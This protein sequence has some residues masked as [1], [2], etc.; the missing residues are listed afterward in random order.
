[1]KK[2]HTVNLICS[3]CGKSQHEVKKLIAGPSVYICDECI[4]LCNQIIGE[5]VSPVARAD[6]SPESARSLIGQLI[7]QERRACELLRVCVAHAGSAVPDAVKHAA[8]ELV[9]ASRSFGAAAKGWGSTEE[10]PRPPSS[11]PVW[12][13]PCLARLTGTAEV[14]QALRQA[15][16]GV[17]PGQRLKTIDHALGEI[18]EGQSAPD[19]RASRV[20]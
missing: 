7:S 18:S 12:L 1:M 13:E 4:G 10:A 16:E 20:D 14:L 3:F 15:L 19:P 17:V 8:S 2:K 6:V 11:V 9:S 5:E